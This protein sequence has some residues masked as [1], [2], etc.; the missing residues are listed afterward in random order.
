MKRHT[1]V[2]CDY[3]GLAGQDCNKLCEWCEKRLAVD[4]HHIEPRGMGNK[5]KDKDV[6]TNLMGLCRP[7]HVEAEAKRIPKEELI[8]KHINNLNQYEN[9]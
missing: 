2:Y 5:S 6:I 4:I 1:K 9:P 8:K 3:F 7:C